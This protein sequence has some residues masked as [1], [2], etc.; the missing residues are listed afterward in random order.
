MKDIITT[1]QTTHKDGIHYKFLDLPLLPVELEKVCFDQLN[2]KEAFL[3]DVG[4]QANFERNVLYGNN[5]VVKKQ[6]IFE[7]FVAP[8]IIYEWLLD[9]KI[10]DSLDSRAGV[11]RSFNGNVLLPHIDGAGRAIRNY[12]DFGKEKQTN[13]RNIAWNYLLSDSGPRT[14]IYNSPDINDIAESVIFEKNV[15][16]QLDVSKYHGVENIIN[17]RVSLSISL[18]NKDTL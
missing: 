15:W 5:I 4:R 12:S 9:N 10:I 3:F 1:N 7:V 14:C 18:I 11:Q 16:H 17:D 8:K 6:C 13:F 2:N